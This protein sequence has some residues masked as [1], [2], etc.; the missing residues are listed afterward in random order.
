LTLGK[1][2]CFETTS[3]VLRFILRYKLI[4]ALFTA[5]MIFYAI[6]N[7]SNP[8]ALWKIDVTKRI[9]HHDIINVRRTS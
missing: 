4:A 8:L 1:I 7:G 5:K 3:S 2:E 9:L 6:D